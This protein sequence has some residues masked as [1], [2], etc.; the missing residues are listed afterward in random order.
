MSMN[1]KEVAWKLPTEEAA[2]YAKGIRIMSDIADS[3]QR[4]G[5]LPERFSKPEASDVSSEL[6]PAKIETVKI[7][8]EISLQE[9][10]IRQIQGFI[11]LGFHTKLGKTEEEYA[12]RFPEFSPQSENSK[13]KL[14]ITPVL[15]ET[16]IGPKDQCELAGIEYVLGGLSRADW[17]KNLK[18][19]ETPKA[20]YAAWLEDGRNNLNKKPTGV[21]KN[22]KADEFGGTELEG[23]A[24]YISNP[25]ILEHHFLDLPGT[26]VESDNSAYLDLWYGRPRLDY[27]FA[28]FAHPEFGS[29]V[30]GSQK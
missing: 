22:L 8:P 16:E 13:G 26:A 6:Q 14:G 24:L 11:K 27:R 19:Y 25:K 15:V 29:V 5:E 18:N 17:N 2:K 20:P 10:R 7:Y 28:A 3:L 30:R 21:R 4:L 1:Y 9:E 12:T 23:I